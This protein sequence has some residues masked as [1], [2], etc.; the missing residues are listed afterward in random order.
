MKRLAMVFAVPGLVSAQSVI[1]QANGDFRVRAQIRVPNSSSVMA[2]ESLGNVEFRIR[3]RYGQLYY[4]GVVRSDEFKF[5]VELDYTNSSDFSDFAAS[6][7]N[8]DYDVYINNAFVGRV[9]TNAQTFGI[10]V[11][12]YDSRHP[13]F[14]ALP[15][16]AAFPEPVNVGDTVRIF[17]AAGGA[18]PAIGSALPAGSPL[19]QSNLQ[20]RFSRGDVNQDGKVDIADFGYLAASYDPYH[21]GGLHIGPGVGDF[22][23]D[24]QADQADYA[25]FVQNWD[26]NDEPPAEPAAAFA[27]CF[28][29]FDNDGP[30]T[31]Q[32]LF[33]FLNAWFAGSMAADFDRSSTLMPQDIFEYLNAWFAGCP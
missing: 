26:D 29:D 27:A 25:L 7:Y 10:G 18:A 13:E 15:L 11:L 6:V 23:G 22:T 32:D 30:V 20:E 19:F 24:N 21:R 9:D 8:T 33:S 17:A 1:A 16:P 14:P 31:I 2:G 12:E 4:G 5:T 3:S 28:A